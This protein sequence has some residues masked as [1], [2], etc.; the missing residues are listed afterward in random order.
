MEFFEFFPG[1][2]KKI[3]ILLAP[4]QSRLWQKSSD[5]DQRIAFEGFLHQWK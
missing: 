5:A 4:E 3:G 2:L 1:I